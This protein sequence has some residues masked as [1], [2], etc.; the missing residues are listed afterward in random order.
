METAVAVTIGGSDN[1]AGAGIQ[2]DLKAFTHFKVYGQTVVT[3]IV[4]ELPGVVRSIQ[5]VEA[6]VIRDQLELSL[7]HLPVAAIKTGMIF[8]RENIDLVCDTYEMILQPERPFLVVDPVMI[9]TSGYPLV[10]PDAIG[11]YKS[12]LFPIAGV[13]TPNLD[14]TS[15]ILGEQ[16]NSLDAMREA[17]RRLYD[18]YGVPFLLK[19]GHL[20][21][22]S[23][24]D[25]L[26]D[27]EGLHEFSE[28]YCHSIS[29]HGTGCTYSAA[30]TAN[31]ALGLPLR[32]AVGVAKKYVTRAI[33]DSFR[34]ATRGS[35][36]FALRHFW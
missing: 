33:M 24:V 5:P 29:T 1:S 22:D 2:A 32:A 8:N 31:I 17:A 34:W 3:C 30:I 26:I 25:Y 11:R 18:E 12:R 9:A 36:V 23:A 7:M 35:E 14:E 6:R 13:I 20:K 28:P 21:T 19:G 10:Q 27:S 15:A 16:V 4:A